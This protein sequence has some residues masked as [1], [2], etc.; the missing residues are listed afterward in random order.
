MRPDVSDEP[1]M[2]R[3]MQL[4]ISRI[5][6]GLVTERKTLSELIEDDAP[7]SRTKS[8]KEYRFDRIAL[9][10][11][12]KNVPEELRKVLR[13]PVT[14]YFDSGVPDSAFLTDER[15]LA[16]FQAQG[17][18]SELRTMRDGRVWVGRAIVYAITRKYPSLVQISVR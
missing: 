3:W 9:R 10:E 11:F 12:S 2:M 8:G 7:V 5:N 4:E 16:A 1:V 6:D 13:V 15:A 18:L 17:D 14:F